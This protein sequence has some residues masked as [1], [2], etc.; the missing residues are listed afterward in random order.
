MRKTIL[1]VAFGVILL[2][3]CTS[4][5]PPSS[6]QAQSLPPATET[7]GAIPPN[8]GTES[9][10]GDK[11][12]EEPLPKDKLDSG[13]PIDFVKFFSD[14]SDTVGATRLEAV[15]QLGRP[16]TGLPPD[17]LVSK[18][19]AIGCLDEDE[20]VRKQAIISLNG[21]IYGQPS[22]KEIKSGYGPGPGA[23]YGVH[24]QPLQRLFGYLCG[25]DEA[26]GKVAAEALTCRK[27]SWVETVYSSRN[28]TFEEMLKDGGQQVHVDLVR[29]A[30]MALF[31]RLM[32]TDVKDRESFS[33]G[34]QRLGKPAVDSLVIVLNVGLKKTER[35]D[36][37]GNTPPATNRDGTPKV[38]PRR[39][40]CAAAEVLGSMG[41]MAKPATDVLGQWVKKCPGWKCF[42]APHRALLL[43][44]E[45]PGSKTPNTNGNGKYDNDN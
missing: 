9:Q 26:A 10:S 32:K 24:A 25:K 4:N 34:F 30:V 44:D 17:Q 27:L 31:D 33:K 18:L 23:G 36:L 22:S 11:K 28:G 21:V 41:A 40:D 12:P 3:G 6:G 14:L 29:E 13:R 16:D 39:E 5:S 20:A 7:G 42:S 2:T 1:A 43:A 35:W 8:R 15:K 45:K 19:V 37:F 38:R